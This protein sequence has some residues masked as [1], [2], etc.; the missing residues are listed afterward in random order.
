VVTAPSIAIP[1]ITAGQVAPRATAAEPESAPASEADKPR[2]SIFA[3]DLA[4]AD[5]DDDPQVR[6]EAPVEDI[7][8]PEADPQAADAA[9]LKKRMVVASQARRREGPD[10]VSETVDPILPDWYDP[11][12]LEETTDEPAVTGHPVKR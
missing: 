3:A 8:P 6:H 10:L 4:P 1:A 11:S 5:E 9:R 7:E 12:T 2:R